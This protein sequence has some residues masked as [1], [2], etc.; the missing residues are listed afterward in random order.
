MANQT[1][2][3][4]GDLNMKENKRTERLLKKYEKEIAVLVSIQKE[5]EPTIEEIRKKLLQWKI[6]L[7]PKEIENCAENLRRRDLLSIVLK[8]INDGREHI[9]KYALNK[10]KNIPSVPHYKDI[11]DY[12]DGKELLNYLDGTKGV[13]K[14]RTPDIKDYWQVQIKFKTIGAVYGFMPDGN[15]IDSAHYRDEKGNIFVKPIH[16][17]NFIAHNLRQLN[18]P[19]S[20]GDYL[21]FTR[22]KVNLNGQKTFKEETSIIVHQGGSGMKVWEVLPI[23]TIIETIASIPRTLFTET[24]F[25]KFLHKICKYGIEGFGGWGKSN[26]GNLELTEYKPIGDFIEIKSN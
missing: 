2:S 7:A 8:P 5:G 20:Q 26:T 6:N 11:V 4:G 24:E 10:V 25:E 14:G 17:R 21:S 22:G 18:K 19:E 9:R 23:G 12:E 16:L 3:L 1:K 13:N 15:G